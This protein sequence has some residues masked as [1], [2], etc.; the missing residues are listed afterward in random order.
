MCLPGSSWGRRWKAPLQRCAG[1]GNANELPSC[2]L[3]QGV[4]SGGRQQTSDLRDVGALSQGLARRGLLK[5][6]RDQGSQM[7]RFERT[8]VVR[9]RSAARA[10]GLAQKGK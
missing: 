10:A 7:K 8:S 6:W 2:E 9:K 3:V 4:R 1:G 5:S